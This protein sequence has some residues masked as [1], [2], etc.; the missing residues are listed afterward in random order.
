MMEDQSFE[1]RLRRAEMRA[2]EEGLREQRSN[3][4]DGRKQERLLR[5]ESREAAQAPFRNR[6]RGCRRG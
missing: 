1:R 4:F 6:G 3:E 2:M 5:K